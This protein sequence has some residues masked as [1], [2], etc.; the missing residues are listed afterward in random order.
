MKAFNYVQ[1]VS[2]GIADALALRS[3]LSDDALALEGFSSPKV[4][5][6]LNN[7][8]NFRGCNYLE[9]G[10]WK[11]S[12]V[13]SAAFRNSGHFTAIESFR[14]WWQ[15]TSPRPELLRNK[16]R[17]RALAPFT[18][19]EIDA[20]AFDISLL[21]PGVNVYFYDGD[22]RPEAT[23]KAFT[24]FDDAL[25]DTFILVMDDWNRKSVRAAT[26]GAT[27]RAYKTLHARQLF[28]PGRQNDPHENPTSWWN[29]VYVAVLQKR[30]AAKGIVDDQG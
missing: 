3:R 29:G 11:G 12:T 4:R 25:A 17:F 22:H 10:T 16:K 30:D 20:W 1:H 18:L 7:L 8:C 24:H 28:T 15:K 9:I 2:N 26:F 21:P 13:I 6:L 19:H 27:M 23:A 14:K 5:H